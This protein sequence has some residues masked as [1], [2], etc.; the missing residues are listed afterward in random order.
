MYTFNYQK[1]K[2]IIQIP[3]AFIEIY[4]KF[5]AYLALSYIFSEIFN[6]IPQKNESDQTK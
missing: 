4:N 3:N 6:K 1:P 2:C 5:K